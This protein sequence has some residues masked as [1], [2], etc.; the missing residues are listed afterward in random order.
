MKAKRFLLY[1]FVYIVA[2]LSAVFGTIGV[3]ALIKQGRADITHS[4]G[5]N[6]G[7]QK[8]ETSDGEKLLN[9]LMSLDTTKVVITF[10]IYTN[11]TT[12]TMSTSLTNTAQTKA[13]VNFDGSLSIN[14]LNDI[15]VEGDLL[16]K[17]ADK[18]VSISISYLDSILYLSTESM[19]IKLSTNSISKII[20]LLPT[21]NIDIDLGASLPEIDTDALM[22]SFMTLKAI[23]QDNG[24]LL[25]P[26]TI[27]EGLSLDI[28]TDSDYIIKSVVANKINLAGIKGALNA[29]LTPD[30][31]IN[32]TAPDG[33]K[34]FVDVTNT[35]SVLDSVNEILTNKKAHFDVDATL[36][37]DKSYRLTGGLDLDFGAELGAYTEFTL[38]LNGTRHTMSVGYIG[39]NLYMSVNALK[40]RLNKTDINALVDIFKEQLGNENVINSLMGLLAGKLPN[41]DIK[42]LLP[43]GL[44]G[45]D[46]NNLLQVA[47]GEDNVIKITI[48]AKGF[49]ID[50]D[51]NIEIG[52]DENNQFSYLSLLDINIA[53]YKLDLVLG[54]S[55]NVNI[56]NLDKQQYA[57]LT[58]ID[59]F[60]DALITSARQILKNKQI[61]FVLNTQADIRGTK[62]NVSANVNLDFADTN[63]LHIYMDAKVKA[64]N[65]TFDLTMSMTGDEIYFALDNIT[66]KTSIAEI[67]N[68]KSALS[69]KLGNMSDV[70]NNLKANFSHIFNLIAGNIETLPTN[71]LKYI[72]TGENTFSIGLD[73][74]LLSTP[75][76][77]S[78]VFGF[79]KTITSLTIGELNL[80]GISA[81][82]D[83]HI[84]DRFVEKDFTQVDTISIANVD[85]LLNAVL[86]SVD[87][88]KQNGVTLNIDALMTIKGK[89]ISV[90]GKTVVDGDTI[91]ADLSI[92]ALG[93][94][95]AVEAYVINKTIY[96]SVDGLKLSMPIEKIVDLLKFQF[97]IE[98]DIDSIVRNIFP[99][100][101]IKD[102]LSGDL[103]SLSLAIIKNI[104]IGED[105][106]TVTLSKDFTATDNDITIEIGY[107][108][109]IQSI[110]ISDLSMKDIAASVDLALS[111]GV[112][113]PTFVDDY[114]DMSS[115]SDL[116]SALKSTIERLKDTKQIALNLNAN[117]NISGKAIGLSGK[118]YVNASKLQTAFSINDLTVY[119][120]ITATVNGKE[121]AFVVRLD[122]GII[123]VD[124]QGLKL[125]IACDSIKDLIP[126]IEKFV[127]IDIDASKFT[128]LIAGSIVSEIIAG[129]YT[130]ISLSLIKQLSLTD[131]ELSITLDKSLIGSSED[132]NIVLGYKNLLSSI[133][134]VNVQLGDYEIGFSAGLDYYFTPS[135]LNADEYQ[136]ISGVDKAINSVLNTIEKVKADKTLAI[137]ISNTNLVM[138]GK[139]FRA[140]GNVYVDFSKIKDFT[141]T[142]TPSGIMALNGYVHLNLTEDSGYSHDI[143]VFYDGERIYLTYNTLN[144]CLGVGELDSIVDV[145]MQL[146]FLSESLKT[147]D[148]TNI[149]MRDLIAE[150]KDKVLSQKGDIDLRNILSQLLSSIDFDA[151]KSGDFSSIDFAWIKALNIGCNAAQICLDKTMFGA[152]QDL[153]VAINYADKITGVDIKSLAIKGISLSGSINILDEFVPPKMADESIYC[154]LDS[155]QDVINS[156][157]NTAIE[158][159]DNKQI[160][161][162]LKT[163]IVHSSVQRD[164]RDNPLK[165]VVTTIHMLDGSSAR[166]E[167]KDA[168]TIENGKNKFNINKMRA[169]INFEVTTITEKFEYTNGVRAQ[170][171]YSTVT[172]QHSIEITFIDNVLYIRYNKMYAKIGGDNIVQL[173]SAV[174]ELLNVEMGDIDIQKITQMIDGFNIDEMLNKFKIEMIEKLSITDSNIAIVI[175]LT[176]VGLDLDEI[177]TLKLDVDYDADS[178]TSLVVKDLTIANNQVDSV[179]IAL[180]EFT[181]IASAP[182]ADYID[183]SGVENLIDALANSKQFTDFEIDGSIN[184]K[185]NVVGI[186]I[187]WNIPVNVKVKL[188]GGNEFEVSAR[189][190]AI[191][192]VP[193]VNDDVPFKVGNVTSGIYSGLNR[194]LHIYIKDN[195]VYLYRSETV[196]TTVFQA[197]RLYE[198]K[199]KIHVDTLLDEPL[200]YIL[201]Y[202]FGFSEKIMAE[203]NKLVNKE[204]QNPLDYSNVLKG[205]SATENYYELVIN[206]QE[207]VE[208]DKLGNMTVGV[209]TQNYNGDKIVGG[210]TVDMNIDLASSV[211]IVLKSDNLNLV[212]IG[213]KTD[214]QEMYDFTSANAGL[215]EGAAWDAYDGDWNLSSQREFVLSFETNC[216]E[217]IADIKG[218]AG[219]ELTLPTLNDYFVDTAS[220]RTYYTFA[221]WYTT[222]S[223]DSDSEYN[224][225]IMPRRDTLLYAKWEIAS[226][227]YVTISFVTNGGE[228]IADITSLV[229]AELELPQYDQ[230]LVEKIGNITYTKR[231][232]GWYVDAE[233][234]NVFNSKTMPNDSVTLYAKWTV[235]KAEESYLLEIID[236]DENIYSHYVV[237]GVKP[238]ISDA[239]LVESTLYYLDAN[240]TEL[241]DFDAFT[242]PS[243]DVK[244]YI[245]NRYTLTIKS[246]YGTVI[247]TVQTIYQ[248]EMIK[249]PQQ[250]TYF[251]D[252]GKEIER[253]DYTFNGYYIGKNK[254]ENT[255]TFSMPK[256]DTTLQADWTVD[257]RK[258]YTVSFCVDFVKPATW[259]NDKKTLGKWFI[260]TECVKAANIPSQPF[261]V[262][263]G[264]YIDLTKYTTSCIYAYTGAYIRKEYAFNLHTWSV[265]GP[266]QLSYNKLAT[267]PDTE[268]CDVLKGFTITGD[269]VFSAVWA[270]AK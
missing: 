87:G 43:N 118:V 93:R 89:E 31:T 242:M 172:N 152:E 47:K 202:G 117:A 28:Y 41:L 210:L 24:D 33:E 78:V 9:G 262:L 199:M 125:K 176:D 42:S 10:D 120:D 108:N 151:I 241:V 221:G 204:R 6:Q 251:Y 196:P 158:V 193:G 111:T 182:A 253:I 5:T 53:G 26:F 64:F 195:M 121:F 86:T 218:V 153:L 228:A 226:V 114:A 227:N 67:D 187:D 40:M 194:I 113:V 197:D 157:L 56:P 38:D 259:E 208:D 246:A 270:Y 37:G 132:I 21:L 261:K 179:S 209:R 258:Y 154:S 164:A 19:D 165:A 63:N 25:L 168:Y 76:D 170:N 166:F 175:D 268:S 142:S 51:I 74:S 252:D 97:G 214:M 14:G 44:N 237:E 225:N 217:K 216:S 167:W 129:D 124:Y 77:L 177:H 188:L 264:T 80:F 85:K 200:Y 104:T 83:I 103:S 16:V 240:F 212:N 256:E 45:I 141:D 156:V 102:I 34:E 223:F 213:A 128:D 110:S 92:S 30:K 60:A 23:K 126:T 146:K 145:V 57:H 139:T 267:Q 81:G 150:S 20:S 232:D 99:T 123:Y 32:I 190:G 207:L 2:T 55:A 135:Q 122:N 96:V 134:L 75:D 73:K 106:T 230:T 238:A 198:K 66:I 39:D 269:T 211:N 12:Q 90:A 255:E 8:P 173:I 231:F 243:A 206:L 184:L 69:D 35:L 149:S 249:I 98:I 224:K 17:M 203:I 229:G 222:K 144:V 72:T 71:L 162:G 247:N 163:D 250:S 59:K 266:R 105:K 140:Y 27:M 46:I 84:A 36:K 29:N 143:T 248:G 159:V 161:F 49:G 91:Y 244:I 220:E 1:T 263:Q 257:V 116:I 205:F 186:N 130:N 137:T 191:P 171:P 119:A 22:S 7:Q 189:L 115:T 70:T 148:I 107:A 155:L 138:N 239:R 48:L 245:R 254:V 11:E 169:Y 136:D 131:H 185:L 178:L 95:F 235:V 15:K 58:N 4:G 181:P 147:Q 50:N 234:N 65:K 160:A 133:A 3:N 82:A 13:T 180:Q 62:A 109:S 112:R 68:L 127:P 236:G 18:D 94:T 215:S 101:N 183:L 61:S 79:D 192:V 100:F 54:Y 265:T 219:S 174:S 201:Q 233:F 88:F 52:L 260:R